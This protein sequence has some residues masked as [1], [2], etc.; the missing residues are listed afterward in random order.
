MKKIIQLKDERIKREIDFSR[1][2][3][4]REDDRRM[5]ALAVSIAASIGLIALVSIGLLFF[6]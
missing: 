1:F 3:D 6:K 4:T 5:E 2:G